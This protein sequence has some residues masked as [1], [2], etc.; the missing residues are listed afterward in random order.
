M[1]DAVFHQKYFQFRHEIANFAPNDKVSK[2]FDDIAAGGLC[3]FG[4]TGSIYHLSQERGGC[5][6]DR[7]HPPNR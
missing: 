7:K 6:Q 4:R 1:P 3:S 2:N 5:P